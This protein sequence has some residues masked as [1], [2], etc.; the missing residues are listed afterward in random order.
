MGRRGREGSDCFVLAPRV[1][2]TTERKERG[3]GLLRHVCSL[4]RK[5]SSQGRGKGTGRG[6]FFSVVA[7]PSVSDGRS[8]PDPVFGMPA[9]LQE[10]REKRVRP[11][12]LRPCS[13]RPCNDG[14]LEAGWIASSGTFLNDVERGRKEG[15]DCFVM[16]A[17]LLANI[18]RKDGGERDWKSEGIA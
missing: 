8:N 16:F 10:Q 17:R 15:L 7:R 12:L 3:T 13:A 14:G 2:A 9:P 5:H 6:R 1:L 4:A 18:P 11:G